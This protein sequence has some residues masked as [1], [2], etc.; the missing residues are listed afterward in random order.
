MLIDRYLRQA[1]SRFL[2]TVPMQ[3]TL[4]NYIVV[5][6]HLEGVFTKILPPTCRAHP[7]MGT[8]GAVMTRETHHCR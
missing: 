8:D 1:V 5:T 6:L 7:G 4:C 3:G 2:E